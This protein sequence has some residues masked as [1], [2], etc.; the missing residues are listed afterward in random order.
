LTKLSPQKTLTNDCDDGSASDQR[1]DKTESGRAD[2]DTAS[3]YTVSKT[4]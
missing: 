2:G 1:T 4:K 3:G